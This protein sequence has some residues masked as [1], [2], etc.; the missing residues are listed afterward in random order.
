MPDWKQQIAERLSGLRLEPGRE[1]AITEELAQHLEEH[2]Q[3]LVAAGA[4]AEQARREA[5]AGLDQQVLARGLQRVERYS[6]AP[7]VGIPRGSVLAGMWQDVRYSLRVLAK[8][9]GFAAIAVLTLALGIA[10]NTAIFSVVNALFLHP[11]GIAD[12]AH[13]VTVRVKYGKLNLP[14]ISIS[15]P[16]Y[17]DARDS[18][19]TFSSVAAA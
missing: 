15:A 10:A 6:E 3:E 2:Y 7:V 9:P 1:A 8:N 4:G 5:L 17:V 11:P 13:V 18:K 19:Q 12:P 16:D 14:N